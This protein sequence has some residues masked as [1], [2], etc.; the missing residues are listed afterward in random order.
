MGPPLVTRQASEFAGRT[1]VLTG[2]R[3]SAC[4][5]LD[6]FLVE[7]RACSSLTIKSDDLEA[8]EISQLYTSSDL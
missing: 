1:F 4:N 2:Q 7:N 8:D 3:I 5:C 6:D